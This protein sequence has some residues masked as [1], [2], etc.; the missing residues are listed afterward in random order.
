MRAAGHSNQ[1][2]HHPARSGRKTGNPCPVCQPVR[3][4]LPVVFHPPGAGHSAAASSMGCAVP[5]TGRADRLGHR[6]SG[7]GGDEFHGARIAHSSHHRQNGRRSFCRAIDLR[8]GQC[9][10]VLSLHRPLAGWDPRVCSH[11]ASDRDCDHFH[12]HRPRSG[13]ALRHSASEARAAGSTAARG[14]LDRR[15]ASK[16]RLAA[17]RCRS[18]FRAKPR[19]S[20]ARQSAMVQLGCRDH[21]VDLRNELSRRRSCLPLG[22]AT[23]ES[24]F[25]GFGLPEC[26]DLARPIAGHPLAAAQGRSDHRDRQS[27]STCAGRVHRAVVPELQVSGENRLPRLARCASP[28]RRSCRPTASRPDTPQP[29]TA[30]A[31]C[32]IRRGWPAVRGHP[33]STWTGDRSSFRIVHGRRAPR[34]FECH[35]P[36]ENS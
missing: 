1:G 5:I 36:I 16:L 4:G 9:P 27:A 7:D 26:G 6:P 24:S 19:S 30:T 23:I 20:H 29:R 12:G 13:S 28:A 2:S 35:P 33:G 17:C 25:A 32:R 11:P 22:R 10:F 8:P 15:R 31:A 34:R 3:C 21:A 14:G 18:L